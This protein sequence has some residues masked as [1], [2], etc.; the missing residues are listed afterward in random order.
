M[1]FHLIYFTYFI[2]NTNYSDIIWN[3]NKDNMT[4]D[5]F[6][7]S[8]DSIE[9]IEE[10]EIVTKLNLSSNRINDTSPFL[11]LNSKLEILDLSHNQ[12][13]DLIPICI[14]VTLDKLILDYNLIKSITKKLLPYP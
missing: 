6:N 2:I 4:V 13:K 3:D 11:K 7:K 8:I 9:G 12:I 1:I 14:F 5:L 10:L